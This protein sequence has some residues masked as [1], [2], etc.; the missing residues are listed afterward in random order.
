MMP[1]KSRTICAIPSDP[2][3]SLQKLPT[4]PPEFILTEKLL[5]D[6][7]THEDIPD[8]RLKSLVNYAP[9]FFMLDVR[10]MCRNVQGRHKV[11]PPTDQCFNMVVQ[12]HNQPGHKG[13][14]QHCRTVRITSG[15][16]QLMQMI[17]GLFPHALYT[18]L[19][20]SLRSTPL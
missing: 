11:V 4:H 3:L 9:H 6:P 5:K 12:A 1:E 7:L 17:A 16:P 19:R 15:G 10:L 2:L 20:R 8:G 14:P 18:R 13:I